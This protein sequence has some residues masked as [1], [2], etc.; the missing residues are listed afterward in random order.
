MT[1]QKNLSVALNLILNISRKYSECRLHTPGSCTL[2]SKRT[3]I[4]EPCR[5]TCGERSKDVSITSQRRA[6]SVYKTQICVSCV[7]NPFFTT[8][9]RSIYY[10]IAIFTTSITGHRTTTLFL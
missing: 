6:E 4:L 1:N 9:S 8:C 10:L 3:R 5:R 2:E 7:M